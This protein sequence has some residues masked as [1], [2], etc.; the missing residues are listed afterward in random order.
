MNAWLY[1]P[2]LGGSFA[3]LLLG[4]PTDRRGFTLIEYES[5]QNSP[6]QTN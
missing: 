3:P 5:I 6:G 1:G 2:W 4:K